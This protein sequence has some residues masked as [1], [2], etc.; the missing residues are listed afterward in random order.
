MEAI[1]AI[2]GA[3]E[4]GKQGPIPERNLSG[5]TKFKRS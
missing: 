3:M 4:I 1:A 5:K 2:I